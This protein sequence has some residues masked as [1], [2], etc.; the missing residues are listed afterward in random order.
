[1]HR[2]GFFIFDD[3]SWL[4]ILAALAPIGIIICFIAIADELFALTRKRQ[5]RNDRTHRPDDPQ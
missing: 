4:S 2:P 5:K 1:M 3:I